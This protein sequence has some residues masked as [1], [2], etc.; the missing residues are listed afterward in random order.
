MMKVVPGCLIT[1]TLQGSSKGNPPLIPTSS[2]IS[3]PLTVTPSPP[4]LYRV[5]L[6]LDDQSEVM[7]CLPRGM[8][9]LPLFLTSSFAIDKDEIGFIGGPDGKMFTFEV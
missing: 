9:P 6:I 5:E 4:L 1:W 2:F 8:D 7:W 3:L